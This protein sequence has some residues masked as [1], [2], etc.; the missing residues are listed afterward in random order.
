ML[1]RAGVASRRAVERLIVDG[2]ITVNGV[3]ITRLG[4]QID[5]ARDRVE[6]DGQRIR[7]KRDR[8]ALVLAVH[9]PAG[10]LTTLED[11]QGRPTVGD[12]IT[13]SNRRVFP[14]GRLDWDAE[15]LVLMTDDGD[16]ANRLAHPRFHVARTYRARVKG[17][18]TAAELRRLLEGV[19]LADGIARASRARIVSRGV[20]NTWIE[21]TIHQGRNHLVKRM[22]EE[23]GHPVLRLRRTRHGAVDLGQ[24]PV[25][26]YRRLEAA[27]IA[28]LEES[29]TEEG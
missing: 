25:G 24:L 9:K 15:G 7:I 22:A 3:P 27:E 10:M 4:S 2:R 5:P 29:C 6:V 13:G 1:A 28:A 23:I 11:P 21:L 19:R 16:L 17:E 26:R 8:A 14:V 12:L 18:V 20:S